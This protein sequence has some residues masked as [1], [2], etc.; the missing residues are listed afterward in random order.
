[1]RSLLVMLVAAVSACSTLNTLPAEEAGVQVVVVTG[2]RL[3]P[4]A[5]SPAKEAE[6]EAR[7]RCWTLDKRVE[8]ESLSVGPPAGP[9][10]LRHFAELRFRCV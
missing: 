4:S 7:F 5:I 6:A 2:S 3:L 9:L 1:M 10:R 8:V